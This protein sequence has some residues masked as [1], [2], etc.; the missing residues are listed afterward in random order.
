VLGICRPMGR[1]FLCA[2]LFLAMAIRGFGAAP[3][4]TTVSDVIYRADGTAAKG[5]VLINW[6]FDNDRNLIGRFG[7]RVITLPRL[8]RV[9]TYFLRLYDSSSP[10]NYSEFSTAIHVN[11][12][13]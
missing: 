9:Q 6:G 4:T 5:T 3:S 1:L 8:S 11:Y 12:P 10:A 13:L 7:T 2:G